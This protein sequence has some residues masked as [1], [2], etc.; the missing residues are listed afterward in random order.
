[1]ISVYLMSSAVG[2]KTYVGSSS[3]MAMRKGVHKNPSTYCSSSI[4]IEEYGWD[5][6][7]FTVLEECTAER[8]GECEQYWIDF[9]P[10]TVNMRNAFLTEEETKEAHKKQRKAYYQ[11][12]KEKIKE[13]IKEQNKAYKEA[14]KEK[15]KEQIKTYYQANREAIRARQKARYESKK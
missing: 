9:V 10:N 14:N 3:N 13:Q 4:L 7:V 2:P 8:R 12:N 11:T 5:N 1:M 6:I 15:I